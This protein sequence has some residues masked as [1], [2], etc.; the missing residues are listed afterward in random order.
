M[1]LEIPDLKALV[2]HVPGGPLAQ[3][4]PFLC[5]QPRR[6]LSRSSSISEEARGK[7]LG[8][9]V[10]TAR[11]LLPLSQLPGPPNC[12]SRALTSPSTRSSWALRQGLRVAPRLSSRSRSSS[13]RWR[14]TRPRS[15]LLRFRWTS[16]R[17]TDQYSD[18]AVP[19]VSDTTTRALPSAVLPKSRRTWRPSELSSLK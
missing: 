2:G 8:A 4:C 11:C 9:R 5:L 17:I 6:D 1:T 18:T 13:S 16:L 7:G 14:W 10:H 15:Q 3:L 12:S 19:S